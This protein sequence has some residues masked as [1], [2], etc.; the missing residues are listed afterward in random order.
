M[1][2]ISVNHFH[3]SFGDSSVVRDISFAVEKGE[4]FALLGAN[5]SGKTTTIRCLL[6][7]LQP[8]SG[9]LLVD[10]RSYSHTQAHLLGYL[11]EERGLYTAAKVLETLVYFGMLKG[12]SGDAAKKWS[13]AYLERVGL[14]DKAQMKIRRLS[15]GQQQKVQ[16]GLT[17]INNPQLLIL[18]EPTKGLD[19]VN[20]GLLMDIL[21]ELNA[22]GATIVF[23]THQMDEVEKIADR[24]LMIKDG[25]TKLYGSVEKVRAQFGSNTVHVQ[26]QGELRPKPEIFLGKIS[27]NSAEL[28]PAE[29]KQPADVLRE[30]VAQ[31]VAVQKFEVSSPSLQEIFVRVS[32]DV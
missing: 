29:G 21:D 24:L 10:G 3:K 2:F 28:L 19:P 17:I 15:S 18:D 1:T 4:I 16:L 30:L 6:N 20:R 26:Y 25:R 8:T 22:A 14:A 27:T 32:N 5:G 31:G 9:S 13:M 11:P 23:I 7:I 12:M